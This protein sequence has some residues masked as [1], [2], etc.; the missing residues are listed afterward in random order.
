MTPKNRTL[1]LVALFSL[2]VLV[3]SALGSAAHAQT[4]ASTQS[5]T[6]AATQSAT[7]A[8]TQPLAP[9]ATLILA[10]YSVPSAAYA[11]IIPL[12][13]K[14]WLAKTGQT[15]TFQTSYQ[16]SGA[17][18]RAVIGG[19]E[20]DVVALSLE[21]DMTKI[22]QA[23]LITHDWK[24][25]PY[26]GFV[27]DSVVVLAVR[28]D[29]PQGIKDWADIAKPGLDV[30][31]PD[32]AS[33]GGAQWNVLAAYG[34]ARRGFVSGYAK[35]D[36]DGLKFVGDV[37]KNVSVMDKDGA[38]SYLTFVH[39]VGD[40]AINYEN[41]VYTS[42]AAGDDVAIVYPASTILIESPAAVVD[43]YVDKHGTRVPAE[44][45][46]NFLWT[47]DAQKIF[48]KYGFRPV[49]PDVAQDATIAKQ[50]PPIKDLFKIDEFGGWDKVST[51]IFGKTGSFTKLLTT[52]KG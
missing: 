33:S 19:L 6:L 7:M 39:G 12:F 52:V 41:V 43:T 34:A 28:K 50:F 44:A 16:G 29:N 49:V 18:S 35:T 21:T 48:A 8:A 14:Q 51:D 22:A 15:V 10:A 11:E 23:G 30:I 31:T 24:A 3:I 25:N 9:N 32:P 26:H 45:F 36:A 1:R 40:V 27:T 17:Q 46:V 13:T 20:A 42:Q 38:S 37:F 2:I 4:P 47:P 5:A